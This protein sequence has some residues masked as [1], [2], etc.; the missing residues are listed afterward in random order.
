MTSPYQ[1]YDSRCKNFGLHSVSLG[2]NSICCP[3]PAIITHIVDVPMRLVGAVKAVWFTK[4]VSAKSRAK[5]QLFLPK[6]DL[7]I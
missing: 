7:C 6:S 3:M 4:C 2:Y 1:G 5:P